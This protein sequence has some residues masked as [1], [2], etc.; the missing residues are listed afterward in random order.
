MITKICYIEG[1]QK[2]VLARDLCSAHYTRSIKY[3]DPLKILRRQNGHQSKNGSIYLSKP[4]HPNAMKNGRILEHYYVMSE[5]LGR[6]IENNEY[7][8]HLDGNRSNNKIENLLLKEKQKF[9]ELDGCNAKISRLNMCNKHYRRYLKYGDPN[10][11]LINRN[12]SGICSV[13]E[14]NDEHEAKGFCVKH[15][16]RFKKYGTALPIKQRK[17]LISVHGYKLI[18]APDHEN[19]N[20][21]GYVAEHRLVMSNYLGRPLLEHENVH[22][23]NGNKIDN[24]ISNLELWSI[25]QPAGQRVEDKV[26]W[27]EEILRTYKSEIKTY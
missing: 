21:H 15:Y 20:S 5:F 16:L 1:C 23:K 22:H 18:Y 7:I 19:S 8:E 14:C 12:E 2:K 4:G 3:G 17:P 27:A 25:N 10:I 26:K 11:I 6:K 13:E 24:D 9:C